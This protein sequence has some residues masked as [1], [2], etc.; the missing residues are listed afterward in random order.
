LSRTRILATLAT[1]TA[2]AAILAACGGSASGDP[3]ET[4]E[5]ATLEGVS[6]GDVDVSL[7]IR[8]DGP[9]GGD[10]TVGLSGP[11]QS[12]GE[13]S[14]PRLDLEVDAEGKD[15]K[16]EAVD[17]QAGLTV[18]SDRA[19]VAYEGTE[20][21]VDPTT[22]GFVK[23]A[24]EQS[25]DEGG[26]D[27][28]NPAAC[29]EAAAGLK[30]TDFIEGAEDEGS[31]DVDGTSTTKLSGELDVEAG[32]D[33]V[34]ELTEDPACRTQLEAAGDALPLDELKDARDEVSTAV[35]QS[36]VEIYIGEDDIVRRVVAHF[37]ISPKDRESV[38]VD[39]EATLNGVNEKQEIS[40]PS[41]A[42]PLALLLRKLDI[43]PLE[44]LE[45]GTSGEGFG[46]LLEGLGSDSKDGGSGA[47]GAAPGGSPGGSTYPSGGAGQEAY[48]DCLQNAETPTDL[49]NCATLQ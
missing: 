34:I 32:I 7:R 21:E 14:L 24:L 35:K 29:Q 46:D 27:A 6:S 43:N 12:E 2:L 45:A 49:Q 13:E 5:N 19:F 41:D 48:L 18:L 3:Q 37:T 36:H 47:E 25:Q 4:I 23:S 22:F 40:A 1:L 11:F 28:G 38:E 39:L 8:S 31:A 9:N 15:T 16:G 30:L 20:Y 44:L 42:K 33:T 17:T 10:L 26:K